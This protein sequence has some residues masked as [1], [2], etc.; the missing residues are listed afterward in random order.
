MGRTNSLRKVW[1][2]PGKTKIPNQTNQTEK[3]VGVKSGRTVP[4][5]GKMEAV[6]G[7]RAR[8]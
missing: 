8:A 2:Y 6:R 4:L 5:I 1:H 7:K 3:E